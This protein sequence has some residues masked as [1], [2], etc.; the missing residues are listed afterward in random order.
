MKRITVFAVLSAAI[1]AV[2]AWLLGLA[3]RTPA[4]HR[5]IWVSA[6]VAYVVQLFTFAIARFAIT[7]N[8]MVGW[9]I[10]VLLR[11]VTLVVYGFLI[12]KP[13]GLPPISAMISL[14]AFFFLSTLIEPVLLK[15]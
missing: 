4:D 7:S 15:L 12:L 10:G 6:T 9:G 8:V 14:V 3:F 13:Y 2:L 1:I 11:L 5:A